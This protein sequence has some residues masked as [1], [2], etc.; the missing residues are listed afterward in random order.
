[1]VELKAS[2]PEAADA[3]RKIAAHANAARGATILWII[4]IDE[5][6]GACGAPILEV[7][8]WLAAVRAQFDGVYPDVTD[9][10]VPIGNKTVV[11]L[12]FRTDRAPYVVKNPRFGQPNGGSI[13]W[14]VPWRE[15]RSTRTATR[16]DLLRLLAPLVPLPDVECLEFNVRVAEEWTDRVLRVHK[17]Y[18]EGSLYVAPA[19]G[20]TVT[21]PTHRASLKARS[22]DVSDEFHFGQFFFYVQDTSAGNPVAANHAGAT[23][24][25]PGIV[26]FSA[27]ISTPVSDGT[28]P[29]RLLC[30]LQLPIVGGLVPC[31]INVSLDPKKHG[32]SEVA[33]WGLQG[34]T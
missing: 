17:W 12:A 24:R 16:Q 23:I 25:S 4:G 31:R 21:L 1:M 18:A 13:N 6:S 27:S 22:S 15:G 26:F 10:N 14:E 5:E 34:D 33:H 2:W 19:P 30:E 28:Y 3:A 29:E 9:V 20:V 11:A 7:A 32:N 8:D